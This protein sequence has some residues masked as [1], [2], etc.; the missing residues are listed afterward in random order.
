ME[1]LVEVFPKGTWQDQRLAQIEKLVEALDG[2][3]TIYEDS[4]GNIDAPEY[5]ASKKALAAARQT[6]EGA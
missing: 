5:K 1:E 4:A 2:M 3:M 6:G